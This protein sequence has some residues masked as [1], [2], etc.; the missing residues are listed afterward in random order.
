MHISKHIFRKF[1]QFDLCFFAGCECL[2]LHIE[3]NL[4]VLLKIILALPIRAAVI[5]TPLENFP[6]VRVP[7]LRCLAADGQLL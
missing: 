1:A 5:P 4:D 6:V 7:P 3:T 2:F